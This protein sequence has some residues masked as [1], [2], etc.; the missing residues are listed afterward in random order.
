ML[1]DKPVGIFLIRVCENRFGFS[2]SVKT[3]SHVVHVMI[4]Q[5]ETGKYVVVGSPKVHSN[6]STLLLFYSKVLS[7]DKCCCAC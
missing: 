3:Q 1:A 6:L 4:S 7:Y 5:L 2:L